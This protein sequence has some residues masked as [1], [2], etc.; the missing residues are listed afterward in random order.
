MLTYFQKKVLFLTK[1]I[2]KG[3]IATY[4]ELAKALRSS[5]RAVGQALGANHRLIKIPCHRVVKSDG[6]LGGYSGGVK[7]KKWLLRKEGIKVRMDK[8][9]NFDKIIFK[10]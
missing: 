7:K 9:V 5:P 8:I 3:K 10:F 6:K 2:P 1:Q 4:G